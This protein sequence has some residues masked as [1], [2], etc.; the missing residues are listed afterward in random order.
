[1]LTLQL[2][3][4][5]P[6]LRRHVGA[7]GTESVAIAHRLAKKG[8]DGLIHVKPFACMPEINTMPALHKLSR[9]FQFPI[10]YFSFDSQT[11]ETGIKTRLEAFYDMLMMKKDKLKSQNEN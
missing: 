10:I 1:M 11:S 2:K 7:H 5:R 3:H 9:D 4:A 8:F 6:Y